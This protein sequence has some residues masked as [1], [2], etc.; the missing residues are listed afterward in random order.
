VGAWGGS[1]NLETN[2]QYEFKDVPPGRY[3]ISTKPFLP[4]Q[5]AAEAAAQSITVEPRRTVEVKLA[6]P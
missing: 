5:N 1:A 3:R 2:G 4:G 6:N